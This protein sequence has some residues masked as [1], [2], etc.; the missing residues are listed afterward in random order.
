MLNFKYFQGKWYCG[1]FP[2]SFSHNNALGQLLVNP[3]S[4]IASN[5][6]VY[7]TWAFMF[8]IIIIIIIIIIKMQ[9]FLFY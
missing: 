6:K 1:S 5:L 9:M 2:I 4:R 3:P 8:I 7:R